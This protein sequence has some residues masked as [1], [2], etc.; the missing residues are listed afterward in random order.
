MKP[1]LSRFSTL[2]YAVTICVMLL[3]GVT[4]YRNVHART[5]AVERMSHTQ[6]VMLQL[7][8]VESLIQDAETG[9]RGYLL[10]GDKAYLRPYEQAQTGMEPALARPTSLTG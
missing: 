10:A 6:H 7:D 4:L 9:Q 8:E 3:S 5:A 2:V 1:G